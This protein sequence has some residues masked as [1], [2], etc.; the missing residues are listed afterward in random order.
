[1]LMFLKETDVKKASA[2][3]EC[4]ICYCWYFLD[5]GFNFL[6]DAWNGCHDVFNDVY[7][8]LRHCYFKYLR[9]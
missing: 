9:F 8:P 1:M 3:K 6:S 4:D 2:P 5:K 7:K